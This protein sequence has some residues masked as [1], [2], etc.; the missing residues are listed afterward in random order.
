MPSMMKIRPS[1]DYMPSGELRN[2]KTERST[3]PSLH[4]RTH[5]SPSKERLEGK[6]YAAIK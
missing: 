6:G 3:R 2:D 5:C 1:R 4:A